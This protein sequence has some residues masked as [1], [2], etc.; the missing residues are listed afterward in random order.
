MRSLWFAPLLAGCLLPGS[1]E[2]SGSG[3]SSGLVVQKLSCESGETLDRY[4]AGAGAVRITVSDGLHAPAYNDFSDVTGEVNDSRDL[5]GTSGTW[6]L[7][8]DAGGFAG[9]FKITLTCL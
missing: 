6:Q 5:G 4:E 3:A 8:V 7:A 1:V 9:Q 2:V